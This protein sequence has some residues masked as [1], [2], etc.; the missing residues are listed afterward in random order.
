MASHLYTQER[1]KAQELSL[2]ELLLIF[3]VGLIAYPKYL[4]AGNNLSNMTE[5]ITVCCCKTYKL[6]WSMLSDM[7]EL[8]WNLTV[9]YIEG[10]LIPDNLL[11]SC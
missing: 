9:D 10:C 1:A 3:V 6:F 7:S 2:E 4:L 5:I 8:F 11:N